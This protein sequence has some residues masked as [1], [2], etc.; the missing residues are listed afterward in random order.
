MLPPRK[1]LPFEP[2]S[3]N[4]GRNEVDGK[5]KTTRWKTRQAGK[6]RFGVLPAPISSAAIS[7]SSTQRIHQARSLG[8]LNLKVRHQQALK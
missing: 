8:V 1:T 2:F 7:T 3:P 4:G 5:L 6:L